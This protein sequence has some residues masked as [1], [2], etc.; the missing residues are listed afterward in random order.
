MTAFNTLCSL[1]FSWSSTACGQVQAV[2][3]IPVLLVPQELPNEEA[4]QKTT[5]NKQT[6]KN[7]KNSK[8]R[9]GKEKRKADSRSQERV[10]ITAEGRTCMSAARPSTWSESEERKPTPA[11]TLKHLSRISASRSKYLSE[12]SSNPI[13]RPGPKRFLTSLKLSNIRK[14]MLL[15]TCAAAS[16]SSTLHT[17]CRQQVRG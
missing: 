10:N 9:R 8:K 4:R 11:T 1:G 3:M 17:G 12:T 5:A 13:S 6:N 14:S 7:K 16:R 15:S 2:T